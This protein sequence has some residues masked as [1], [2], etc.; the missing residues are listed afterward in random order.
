MADTEPTVVDDAS[1]E[2]SLKKKKKKKKTTGLEDETEEITEKTASM[3]LNEETPSEDAAAGDFA[4]K[5]KKKKKPV[6]D[7]TTE[8]DQPTT[9]SATT[10][11]TTTASAGDDNA[12]AENPDDLG[13]SLKKKKKK[14]KAAAETDEADEAVA[15]AE[16]AENDFLGGDD[17]SAPAPVDGSEELDLSNL[18]KKKKKKKA[19]EGS[20]LAGEDDGMFGE[21]ESASGVS[22]AGNE[23]WLGSDRDYTYA[24]LLQRAFDIMRAKNPQAAVG[25]KRK[26]VMKPP[27]VTRVGTKKCALSNFQE[28]CTLMHRSTEHVVSFILAELG[29]TGSIDAGNQ[30]VIR[31]RFQQKQIE[32]VLR[33]YI[34][35]YV[36][37]HTCKSPQTNLT[38]ENRLSFL[39][40]ETCGSS[41]SVAA[42]KA[43]FQAI[44]TKRAQMRT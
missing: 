36:T 25:E 26:F 15:A 16:A 13:L 40:C 28:I 35:E 33:H 22:S 39:Q 23:A 7:E 17:S 21:T 29:T 38:K 27:Q 31:G 11:T 8:E 37:C 30:L 32:N 4:G 24:E 20:D 18:K 14:K 12:S 5:K 10:T 42:I 44:T 6:L 43:G 34:R 19:T 41:C 3:S 2:S 1:F 9:P